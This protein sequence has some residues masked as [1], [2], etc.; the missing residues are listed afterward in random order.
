MV[1]ELIDRVPQFGG[2]IS[3]ICCFLHIINLI[4]KSIIHQFD[5]KKKDL[6]EIFNGDTPE[7][8]GFN[9]CIIE[10]E[11]ELTDSEDHKEL[12]DR[13]LKDNNDGWIDEVEL[14][15]EEEHNTLKVIIW[16]VKLVLA[17]V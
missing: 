8:Q 17:K 11:E 3:H 1:D 12:Q 16:P 2:A 4:A 5:V 6:D 9:K 7:I 15:S 10:G 13:L 14:L